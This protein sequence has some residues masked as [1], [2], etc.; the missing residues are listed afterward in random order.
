MS[1]NLYLNNKVRELGGFKTK[2]YKDNSG[3]EMSFNGVH[4]FGEKGRLYLMWSEDAPVPDELKDLVEEISCYETIPQMGCRES[5]IYRHESAKCE[6]TPEDYGNAKREKPMYKL[7]ITAT[8]IEDIQVIMHKVKTGTIRP[9]ESYEGCQQGKSRLELEV[10]IA[11]LKAACDRFAYE[12]DMGNVIINDLKAGV[13]HLVQ[14]NAEFRKSSN[15]ALEAAT[16]RFEQLERDQKTDHERI[17]AGYHLSNVLENERWP[18]CSKK[19][20]AERIVLAL[21]EG[22]KK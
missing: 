21:N 22:P 15:Q 13:E 5:G 7:K 19:S 10:E 8:K 11:Q 12:R 18:F 17:V 6:L 1:V 16:R 2:P 4:V 20:V 3:D 9:E 14:A